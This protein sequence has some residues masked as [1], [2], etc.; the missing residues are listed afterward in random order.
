MLNAT[1]FCA[2]SDSDNHRGNINPLLVSQIPFDDVD[3]NQL[4]QQYIVP[5]SELDMNMLLK[6]NRCYQCPVCHRDVREKADFVRHYMIHT[7]EKPFC[8]KFCPY[9]ATR[10]FTLFRHIRTV[11]PEQYFPKSVSCDENTE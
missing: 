2:S 7:G 8:C 9:K 3:E 1:N 4:H 11:H 6:E 5:V 10:K